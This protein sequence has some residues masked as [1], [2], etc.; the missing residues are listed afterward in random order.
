MTWA[1]NLSMAQI[2]EVSELGIKGGAHVARAGGNGCWLLVQMHMLRWDRREC[3]LGL[4][5]HDTGVR[6][7]RKQEMET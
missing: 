7:N 1:G 3:C 6:A 5:I 4:F 2:I